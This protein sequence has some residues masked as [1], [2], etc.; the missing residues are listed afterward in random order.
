M[1]PPDD[2][3]QEFEIPDADDEAP[4]SKPP[5]ATYAGRMRAEPPAEEEP[6]PVAE[7]EEPEAPPEPEQPEPTA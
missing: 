4:E 7:A 2:E 6:E 1:R 3:T 5:P